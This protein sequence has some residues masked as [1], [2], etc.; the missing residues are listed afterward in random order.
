MLFYVLHRSEFLD[1]M[2]LMGY[3]YSMELIE[4]TSRYYLQ[5][6]VHGSTMSLVVYAYVLFPFSQDEAWNLYKMFVLSDMADI[7]GGTTAE[8][9][10]IVPMAASVVMLLYQLCGIDMT[11]DEIKFYPRIP[12]EVHSL[13]LRCACKNHWLHVKIEDS[14]FKVML[15]ED[16]GMPGKIGVQVYDKKFV[17]LPDSRIEVPILSDAQQKSTPQ[18][19]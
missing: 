14:R 4:K 3:P 15:D 19:A 18:S 12:S 6:S 9:I 11:G 8:G 7:Q 17:L 10:H 2:K 5:R 1:T 16:I 13:E